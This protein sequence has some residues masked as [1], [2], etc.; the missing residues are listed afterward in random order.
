MRILIMEDDGALGQ[1]LVRGL[2]FEGYE[3]RLAVDGRAGLQLALEGSY[4]LIVLDLSLPGMDGV[5]VLSEMRRRSLDAS[6]LVLT[7][8]VGVGERIKCLD[9]GADDYLMKPFSFSELTARCRSLVRRRERF[10]DPILRQGDLELNRM[11]RKVVRDGRPVELTVKEFALLEYLMLARGRT[12][13]RSEL[14]KE[15]W[16]MS[17]DA[18]TNVV[19]VYV[20]YLRKKLSA[21][22]VSPCGPGMEPEQGAVIDT[23][24]GEGYSLACGRKPVR[25]AEPEASGL[26]APVH[27]DGLQ[28]ALAAR[29]SA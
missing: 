11:E 23:V 29:A 20:N 13:S 2:T 15:V 12:C 22:R 9:L 19:D 28:L 21:V 10:A 14:L 1:F 4:E 27:S 16:Q 17:P 18:G 26:L 25:S 8:R 7:G 3:T 24:R 5:Q 6:V